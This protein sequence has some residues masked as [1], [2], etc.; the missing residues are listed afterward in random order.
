MARY[1]PHRLSL[2]AIAR[3]LQIGTM[4]KMQGLPCLES[5]EVAAEPHQE[6]HLHRYIA[7][8]W[9]SGFGT[10]PS[11]AS[12]L[13]CCSLLSDCCIHEFTALFEPLPAVEGKLRKDTPN[14]IPLT[15]QHKYRESQPGSGSCI[16]TRPVCIGLQGS[17]KAWTTS[18]RN[19]ACLALCSP[20]VQGSTAR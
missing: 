19:V 14:M 2:F 12:D 7:A 9:S 6:P 18:R 4:R 8:I 10:R 17:T 3:A 16:E 20:Q 13:T 5:V 15:L 11:K 1:Q